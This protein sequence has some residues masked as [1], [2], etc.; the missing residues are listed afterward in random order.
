MDMSPSV[1]ST[2]PGILC[3]A[4]TNAATPNSANI[5]VNDGGTL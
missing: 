1:G 2:Y 3:N 5:N 4:N